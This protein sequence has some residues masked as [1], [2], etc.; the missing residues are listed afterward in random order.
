[1]VNIVQW[2]KNI[3]NNRSVQKIKTVGNDTG[4]MTWFSQQWKST[5]RIEM[6]SKALF[7]IKR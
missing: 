7:K 1:M 2:S 5:R 6:K 3:Q 4:Q